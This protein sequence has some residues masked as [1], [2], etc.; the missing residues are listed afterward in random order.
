MS[1]DHKKT[2]GEGGSS[3]RRDPPTHEDVSPLLFWPHTEHDSSCC[4]LLPSSMNLSDYLSPPRVSP[5]R[6]SSATRHMFSHSMLSAHPCGEQRQKRFLSLVARRMQTKRRAKKQQ[7]Q[8][9]LMFFLS[10]S[11]N[12]VQPQTNDFLFKQ[13]ADASV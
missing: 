12:K 7:P 4:H 3:T 11:I 13:P 9:W 1:H 10:K 6:C 5:T 2:F 8:Q